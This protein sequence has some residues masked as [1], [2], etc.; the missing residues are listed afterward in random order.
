MFHAIARHRP[1]FVILIGFCLVFVIY[2]VQWFGERGEKESRSTPVAGAKDMLNHTKGI[3]AQENGGANHDHNHPPLKRLYICGYSLEQLSKEIFPDYSFQ[4]QLTVKAKDQ[5][6]PTSNDILVYG[7]FGP[8]ANY[9]VKKFP[10]ATIFLNGESWRDDIR[11]RKNLHQYRLG[12]ARDDGVYSIRLY[13][14]AAVLINEHSPW[15]WAKITDPNQRPQS[16]MEYRAVIYANSHCVRFRQRAARDI[17]KII[18][19]VF[20]GKCKVRSALNSKNPNRD[21][22]DSWI[23]WDLVGQRRYQNAQIFTKFQFC[24]VM[25]NTNHEGYITEKIL[26]AYLGGCLPIY[27][28]TKEVFELFHPESFVYYDIR[29]PEPALQLLKYLYYNETAFHERMRHPILRHGNETIIKY[30]SITD[31][32]GGGVLKNRIRTMIGLKD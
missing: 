1:P 20:G 27:Y 5:Q 12:P 15:E 7:T 25:E 21:N 19:V 13:Y 10:G 31:K 22:H 26:N 14:V 6:Q 24:L 32:L 30:F 2:E 18:P 28:G 16:T 29:N 4:G 11:H 17:A 8:C 3:L 23:D 9:K